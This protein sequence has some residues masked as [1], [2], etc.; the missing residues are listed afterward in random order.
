[1]SQV[2]RRHIEDF[3]PW[4]AKRPG[5]A[6]DKLNPATMI[7]RLRT[8]GVFFIRLEV[9]DWGTPAFETLK[10][11]F[12]RRVIEEAVAGRLPAWSSPGPP[13]G[14]GRR[15]GCRSQRPSGT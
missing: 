13:G 15:C 3:K 9:F 8:L 12:R 4:L 10:L 6:T 7:H 1:M 14:G 5:R 2:S 11:E